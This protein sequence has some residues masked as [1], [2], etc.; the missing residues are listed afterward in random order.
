MYIYAFA[1]YTQS[2]DTHTPG[3]KSLLSTKFNRT[4]NF[5]DLALLGAQKCVSNITLPEDTSIY[6][7]SEDGNLNTTSNVLKSIF[8]E[9]KAPM[10]FDFL[11]SVNAASLYY[12]ARN[13]NLSGKSIFSA[14]FDSLFP[15][16]YSD[17]LQGK[18]VLAGSVTEVF[19][20]LQLHQKRFPNTPREEYS[21]WILLSEKLE[22]LKP[23]AKITHFQM[24]QENENRHWEETFFNFLESCKTSLHLHTSYFSFTIEKIT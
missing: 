4:D 6:L 14:N 9:S 24:H 3:K 11:N 21:R 23:L 7:S 15:Q 17:L 5:I 10:P 8:F 2:Y 20:D 12:I 13:F 16:I 19:E 18:T 22:G 1:N